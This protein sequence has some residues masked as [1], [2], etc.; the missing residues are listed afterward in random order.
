MN[1]IV[2]NSLNDRLN[3]AYTQIKDIYK[4]TVDLTST[5]FIIDS[6][7]DSLTVQKSEF[8][9]DTD[10]NEFRLG[11]PDKPD[12][13]ILYG[14]T[15]PINLDSS[16]PNGSLYLSQY[17]NGQGYLKL[18]KEWVKFGS[19]DI[20][21]NN[22]SGSLAVNKDLRSKDN[23][24]ASAKFDTS[25]N[26][27]IYG[28]DNKF[29]SN[30]TVT[31][32]LYTSNFYINNS[33]TRITSNL[34]DT[35]DITCNN[36]STT[37]SITSGDINCSGDISSNNQITCNSLTLQPISDA[38]FPPGTTII[39]KANIDSSGNL[40]L[41]G[42]I[43]SNGNIYLSNATTTNLNITSLNINSKASIDSSG[44]LSASGINISGT[45]S[46]KSNIN[47]SGIIIDNGIKINSKTNIDSSGNIDI[48]GNINLSGTFNTSGNINSSGSLNGN[49]LNISSTLI[50]DSSGNLNGSGYINTP[51]TTTVTGNVTSN[52][53]KTT[54]SL[55]INGT[56]T[57][58]EKISSSGS[59]IA[60]TL[61]INSKLN[62]GNKDTTN[63]NL[64]LL[65][66]GQD[67]ITNVS[68]LVNYAPIATA[69][70]LTKSPF[71][72]NLLFVSSATFPQL[73]LNFNGQ[74]TYYYPNN[75]DPT[76][77]M[78]FYNNG[79]TIELMFY[80][81]S[82]NIE[83]RTI[84]Y[85]NRNF[86]NN[87][88]EYNITLLNCKII[89]SNRFS[90]TLNDV[91]SSLKYSTNYNITPSTWY[92]L[93]ISFDKLNQKLAVWFG[94]G[95]T[96]SQ[97]PYSNNNMTYSSTQTP[98]IVIGS[99][100]EKT[101]S[102]P[103]NYF[104]G[105]MANI[106][107]SSTVRYPYTQST[108]TKPTSYYDYV[109]NYLDT[110][111][112]ITASG[113]SAN[114]NISGI[115]NS[116][117][118]NVNSK[119]NVR[120]PVG[121]YNSNNNVL[122]LIG[123]DDVTNVSNLV[124]YAPLSKTK[125]LTKGTANN[126]S[127]ITYETFPT[128]TLN[129]NEQQYFYYPENTD[130]TD[131]M[132]FYMNGG[133]V[134]MM[135]RQSSG[136]TKTLFSMKKYGEAFN[137]VY[138]YTTSDKIYVEI[139]DKNFSQLINTNISLILGNWYYL[140]ISFD[141]N[142]GKLAV[143][144]GYE[145][146]VSRIGLNDFNYT[147][148]FNTMTTIIGAYEINDTTYVWNGEM[149]NIRFTPDILYPYSQSTITK[150]TTFYENISNY[151]DTSGTIN[152]SGGNINISGDLNTNTSNANKL[153]VNSKLN[154]RNGTGSYNSNSS[155]LLLVGQDNTSN[156]TSL[157]NY[158]PPN[159]R[160]SLIK[161]TSNNLK[162]N[163]INA[164]FPTKTLNF[165]GQQFFYYPSNTDSTDPLNFYTN[166]GTIQFMYRIPVNYYN[167]YLIYND[168]MFTIRKND[169]RKLLDIQN[170]YNDAYYS[171]T[172]S[173]YDSNETLL[174][175]KYV[176]LEYSLNV[177]NHITISFDKNN[178]KVFAWINNES[179]RFANQNM[180][181]SSIDTPAI[182]IGTDRIANDNGYAFNGDMANIRFTSDILFP[183]PFTTPTL[184]S[185]Y[186]ETAYNYLD[187]QGTI[188]A[189]GN[190]SGGAF[191]NVSIKSNSV[192]FG[193]SGGI[194]I[195]TLTVNKTLT[196]DGTDGT[197]MT[198]PSSTDTIVGLTS[199]Q[200][201]TN[202]TLNLSGGTT[203]QAPLQFT[204]SSNLLTTPSGGAIEYDGANYYATSTDASGSS[205]TDIRKILPIIDYFRLDPS[206]NTI[207]A[208]TISDIFPTAAFTM[209]TSGYYLLEYHLYLSR[210][211]SGQHT[212]TLVPSSS[213][214]TYIIL[215]GINVLT[216]GNAGS[217][218][219]G[220]GASVALT[221]SPTLTAG[222]HY[223]IIRAYVL[224]GPAITTIKLRI[225]STANGV[226]VK[227]GSY[228]IITRMPNSNF[229]N[230]V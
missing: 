19:E 157:L 163:P 56:I 41:S 178:G 197:T 93:V 151:L 182:I 65:L 48:C 82:S 167:L 30:L 68:N 9:I 186:F 15:S 139:Y 227:R 110:S 105:Y 114:I 81:P 60:N 203:T 216:T 199:S 17:N 135:F 34:I 185:A 169:G 52:F 111:G 103:S 78:N 53:L 39:Y 10:K 217:M 213:T 173:I 222:N 96:I 109:N 192:G 79:G 25:G 181:Y 188:T 113:T 207:S 142:N 70:N 3:T 76:D 160:K 123:L 202:K 152:V 134:E 189:S 166:G 176:L 57:A 170:G 44:N 132:N 121:S 51:G 4:S 94:S 180:T 1:N 140:A 36:L 49:R 214:I 90:I 92:H 171:T 196:F 161:G 200:I 85:M 11:N 88:I 16:A 211:T 218:N 31:D 172:I 97:L 154:L 38:Y 221:I 145:A 21:Y 137:L 195:K 104:N 118:L 205:S 62:I 212:Y 2:S 150:P 155:L 230:F 164:S 158:A 224:N 187:T 162:Y 98:L 112:T 116:N 208:T 18:D 127:F 129:F 20:S 175:N 124:N 77:T 29:K 8:I 228:A 23:L 12:S 63:T 100:M 47:S 168:Y 153:N 156:V 198:F 72:N 184:P 64:L 115:I 229:G 147:T 7:T 99:L 24:T 50:I 102:T 131:T 122:L 55:N 193:I 165:S 201:L 95:S 191:N 148:S 174:Y 225:T 32:T 141:K 125:A 220:G 27:N 183:Y 46:V 177:W 223:H 61:N 37:Q 86:I 133:T 84:L 130:Q 59:L 149:T 69:K 14:T 204:S 120:N 226:T 66:I 45:L 106:R 26:I 89:S 43:N 194:D 117:T 75:V 143:W 33:G 13:M 146:S 28:I 87:N 138:I 107:F 128:K 54:S 42:N 6:S 5:P 136:A 40:D 73:S 67:N 80:M 126:L 159:T 209:A 71:N 58:S 144:L 91:N 215:G 35:N 83:D 108:I 219:F 119:L 74:Q 190:I 210:S 101:S 179:D 22:I 206:D